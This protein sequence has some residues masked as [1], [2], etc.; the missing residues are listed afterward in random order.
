LN[1]SQS[2]L[3]MFYQFEAFLKPIARHKAAVP[4]KL[5]G[6]ASDNICDQAGALCAPLK[7]V[8]FF[9]VGYCWGASLETKLLPASGLH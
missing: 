2:V 4:G 6:R 5:G 3:L 8:P 9:I 7:N 1:T